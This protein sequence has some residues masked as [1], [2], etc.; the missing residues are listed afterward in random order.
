M[1]ILTCIPRQLY[2]VEDKF[3]WLVSTIEEHKP[4]VL[5]TPQEFFG[6][7]MMM[8]DKPTFTEKELLPRLELLSKQYDCGL[9]VGVV[10]R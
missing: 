4:D 3:K 6:G 1:K 9:I 2:N 7:M 10:E 8:A 5:V